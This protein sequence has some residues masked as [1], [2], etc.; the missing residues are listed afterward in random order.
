[1]SNCK[2]KVDYLQF[3]LILYAELTADMRFHYI[4]SFYGTPGS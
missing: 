2:Y 3:Y 1:M 4:N